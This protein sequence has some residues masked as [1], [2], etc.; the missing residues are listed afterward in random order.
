MFRRLNRHL[1]AD[2]CVLWLLI[3]TFYKFNILILCIRDQ[4]TGIIYHLHLDLPEDGDL[5]A[6]SYRRVQTYA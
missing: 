3:H 1:H 6:E 5:I 4:C 2:C